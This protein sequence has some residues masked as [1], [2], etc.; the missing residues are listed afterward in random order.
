MSINEESA[1]RQKLPHST[2]LLF[3]CYAGLYKIWR[4]GQIRKIAT[5]ITIRTSISMMPDS[6][7]HMRDMGPTKAVLKPTCVMAFQ[8]AWA[9]KQGQILPVL[10][11]SHEIK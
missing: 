7:I 11:R 6:P 1:T 10:K 5:T 9:I 3:Y 8:A 2:L 4:T